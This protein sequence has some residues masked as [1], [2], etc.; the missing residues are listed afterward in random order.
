MCMCAC[1]CRYTHKLGGFVQLVL[2]HL[3]R[4]EVDE[5]IFK[6]LTH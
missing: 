6:V 5:A 2:S 3:A 4:F 1:D